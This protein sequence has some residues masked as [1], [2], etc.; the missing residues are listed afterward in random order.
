MTPWQAPFTQSAG[1]KH[2]ESEPHGP[3]LAEAATQL[4][5]VACASFARQLVPAPHTSPW[6]ALHAAPAGW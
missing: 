2:S 3:P 1:A 4:P 6:A 5:C